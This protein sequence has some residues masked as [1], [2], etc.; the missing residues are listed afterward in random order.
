ML[1]EL[2]RRLREV[3]LTGLLRRRGESVKLF[4][5]QKTQHL[6]HRGFEFR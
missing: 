5:S 2:E 6:E 4:G 1:M 3:L